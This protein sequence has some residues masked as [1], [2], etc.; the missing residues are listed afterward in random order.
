MRY[1]RDWSAKREA[2]CAAHRFIDRRA[3]ST[4]WSRLKL[5]GAIFNAVEH[6]E[7]VLALYDKPANERSLY[8]FN[9]EPI[10]E[11]LKSY[12]GKATFPSSFKS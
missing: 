11:F 7:R 4:K 8:P 1:L 3:C 10:D 9:A 2:F 12:A 6:R 5:P